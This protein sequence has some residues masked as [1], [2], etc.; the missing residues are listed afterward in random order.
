MMLQEEYEFLKEH[1]IVLRVSHSV[2]KEVKQRFYQIYNRITGENRRP[3]GCGR[4]FVN[5]TKLLKHYYENYQKI[6]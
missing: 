1:E 5:V 2:T 3:N 4:C 6:N